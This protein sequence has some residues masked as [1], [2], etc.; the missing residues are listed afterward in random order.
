MGTENRTGAMLLK[1]DSR[2]KVPSLRP[3]DCG[4]RAD[5]RQRGRSFPGFRRQREIELLVEGRFSPVQAIK[6]WNFFERGQSIWASRTR[7]GIHS[8]GK[9][10]DLVIIKR[11][12]WHVDFGYV[13]VENLFKDGV[14]YDSQKLI[15]STKGRYG[16]Y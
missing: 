4:G 10:A 7:F 13:K 8:V 16:Q 3:E 9:N 6:N 15:D 11:R 12:S 5:P 1:R 2:W 14:G